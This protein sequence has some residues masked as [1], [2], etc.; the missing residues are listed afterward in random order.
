M[1]QASQSLLDP[2][3][4]EVVDADAE[5]FARMLRSF[6]PPGTFDGHV[7]L[8]RV[9]DQGKKINPYMQHGPVVAG[10]EL[11]RRSQQRWMGDRAPADAL[12]FPMPS[13]E[14]NA[15]AANDFNRD[16]A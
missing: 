8:Y 3:G 5:L 1:A 9:A 14:V 15:P 16:E 2:R 13:P 7:H 6:V 12:F 10:A 4:F 11:C